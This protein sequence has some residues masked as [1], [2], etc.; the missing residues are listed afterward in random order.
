MHIHK[1]TPKKLQGTGIPPDIEAKIPSTILGDQDVSMVT[2]DDFR[3]RDQMCAAA[4]AR[5]VGGTAVAAGN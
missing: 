4:G 5:A 1:H 3:I 2:P